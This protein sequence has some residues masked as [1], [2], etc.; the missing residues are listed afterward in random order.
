MARLER[1]LFF[2]SIAIGILVTAAVLVANSLGL[3]DSLEYWLYD[4]RVIYCQLDAPPPT[5]RFVHVDIDDASLE[6]LG[7]WPWRRGMLARILDELRRAHPSALGLDILFSEP[8]APLLV[9]DST[10]LHTEDDDA[11]LA[12]VLRKSGNAVLATSFKLESGEAQS[13]ALTRAVD[14]FTDNLEITPEAFGKRLIAAGETQLSGPAIDD[15]FLRA[16]REA[17]K[18]RID[19]QLDRGPATV[20]ALIPRLLPHTS[21]DVNSP[22]IRTLADQYEISSAAHAVYRFGA[23]RQTL[24][25]APAQGTLSAIPLPQFSAAAADCAFANYDIFD[26]ATVRSVPL[27]AEYNHRLYPQMGLATACVMLGADPTAVRFEGS[28]II[29][30][31]R[32]RTI[33][34]PTYV[35]HSKALGRDVPLIVAVPWFGGRDWETMYDWPAHRI[36]ADHISIAK[37]SD[38]CAAEDAIKKNSATIDEAISHILDNDRADKLALDPSLARK[39]AAALP[40]PRDTHARERMADV[41]LKELKESGWLEMFAQTPDKELKPDERLQKV[42]LQDAVDALKNTVAQ[43]H[44][45]HAQVEAQR[46]WL[47]SQI[48][49]KGILVGF[50]ATGFQDQVSTSL[51]LHCPGVVV[52]GV[53]ANAV[54]TGHWWHVAPTWVAVLLT[55][56]LGVGAA[57]LQGRF[58]PPRASLLVLG[59][60]VAYAL[61]NGYVLFDWQKWIVGI[62]SPIVAIITVWAACTL[63]RLIIEGIE[64]NRIATEVA[65]FSREMELAR[66]VQVALIPAKPPK[67]AGFEAEGWAIAASVTGGDC[68]DLWEMRDG[69]LAILLADAS[70][71][72]LAP[73]MI[74]SQVRTLVR[75]LSEFE[76]HP[77][78]L[79]SRVNNRLANDL[80]HSRFVTAFLGFLGLDGRLEWASAGHGPMY[81]CADG[82]GNLLELD[83]TS[84][85]LGIEPNWAGEETTPP[86]QI[87]AGGMLVVFSDGIF[88]APAPDGV[89]FGVE[90]IKEILFNSRGRPSIQIIAALRT[91]VQQWQGKIEP[92]DDQTIVVV[93]RVSSSLPTP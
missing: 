84:L 50:T 31:A 39:Y 3:L 27:F 6:A 53:I 79:L 29:I 38:I 37:I 90:K 4:Q 68:Y 67:V 42:L 78:E 54:L 13:P 28:N 7:R 82:N 2:R 20:E 18:A 1:R 25:L 76:T 34:I 11:E 71:H 85:P 89:M 59:L 43:N 62:A 12:R 83:S 45:L 72:G 9:Q 23:P 63:D 73:A 14:W 69:R 60:L 92:I 70:G 32:G 35:Y 21:P 75:T 22:L 88:E 17:M 40:D 77:Y 47:A 56:I 15:L 57:T 10:G 55:I 66:Q 74:V 80:D 8:Q 5:T 91:A 44:Q 33:S 51:H 65:I 87:Q 24:S 26:N 52:H 49:G 41:T 19:R 86:L 48:A 81:W 93:R 16:R 46:R 30:P 61:V 36:A 58:S 64:R